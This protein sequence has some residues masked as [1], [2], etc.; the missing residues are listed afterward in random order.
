MRHRG[1]SDTEEAH[2]AGRESAAAGKVADVRA[3]DDHLACVRVSRIGRLGDD[4]DVIAAVRGRVVHGVRTEGRPGHAQHLAR[5]AVL[6]AQALQAA[7]RVATHDH[8]AADVLPCS[9]E[10]G[11]VRP[12]RV[13]PDESEEG[14]GRVGSEGREGEG[15][16]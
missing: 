6:L 14:E 8:A 16:I 13:H 11:V 12:V 9:V 4:A 5:A 15:A 7:P 2:G 10:D 1:R 3:G